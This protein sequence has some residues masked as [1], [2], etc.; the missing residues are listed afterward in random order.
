MGSPFSLKGM[1]PW[2]MGSLVGLGLL[3]LMVSL[4]QLTSPPAST[5][6]P[7]ISQTK[8]RPSEKISALGR[9]EPEGE[10]I[11]LSGTPGERI[12]KLLVKEGDFVQ[13]GQ[14]LLYL[15]SY[16]ER[17]A[18]RNLAADQLAEAQ[19]RL[20]AETQLGEA[21]IAEARSRL[22]QVT[23]P[24]L[25][26]MRAQKATIQRIAAELASSQREY[27]RFRQL[28]QAGAISQQL[29][30]DKELIVRSRTEELEAAQAT[31]SQISNEEQT[32]AVNAQD[33]LRSAQANLSRSQA[34]ILVN[35]TKRNLELAEA[36]LQRTIIR[37]PRAGQILK[38]YTW[39]GE[40]IG[41]DGILQLGNTKQMYAVAEVYETDVPRI[42]VGQPALIKSPAFPQPISGQVAQVG[43]LI[44]KNDVIDTDPAAKTDVRVVEVKIRL[45]DSRI[46]AGL[47]N[48]Q[49]EVVIDPSGEPS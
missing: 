46:A 37:S 42:K 16:P 39:A 40:A 30:E 34:Q 1:N 2:L 22:D 6:N 19:K 23:Q 17:L 8:P 38:I 13:P 33:Q 15:D 29:L 24:K 41:T 11:V 43:L 31:L 20:Q 12:G 18:E 9:L 4:R 5:P 3:T 36:R 45:D 25:A 49:V 7:A 32:N 28:S 27:Q 48:L 35:S 44:A 26:Q 21:Q 47:T 14:V 10:S